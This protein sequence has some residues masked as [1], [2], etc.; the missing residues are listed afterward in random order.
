MP[1]QINILDDDIRYLNEPAKEELGKI[2][3]EHTKEIVREANRLEANHH[4]TEG[5]P[6]I[7]STLIKDASTVINRGYIIPRKKRWFYIVKTLAII[8]T[9]ITGFLFDKLNEPW[10]PITFALA[11]A[12]TTILTTIQISNE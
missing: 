6:E 4:S 7:T 2:L 8:G 5:N 12:L 11:F 10:G 9:L 1:L 3:H